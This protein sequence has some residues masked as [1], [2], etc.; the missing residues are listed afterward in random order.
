VLARGA[1]DV[2]TPAAFASAGLDGVTVGAVA[3]AVL[4]AF[5]AGAF[6]RR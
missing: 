2:P 1:F 5:V 4:L 3:S 6:H